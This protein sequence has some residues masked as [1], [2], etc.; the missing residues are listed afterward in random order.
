MKT[1]GVSRGIARGKRFVVSTHVNP[2]ADGVGACVALCWMLR[3]MGKSA[4]LVIIEKLPRNLSFIEKIFPV[5]R[6]FTNAFQ[7][8]D[9]FVVIDSSR[10]ERT[11]VTQAPKGLSIINI[12]HHRDNSR[13][14]DY[15]WV[16]PCAPATAEMVYS[17]ISHYGFKPE[18][19]IAEVLYAGILVDTGGFKFSNTQ[20]RVFSVC[21][22]L[23][24]CGIDCHQLYRTVF[25][26]KSNGRIRLEGLLLSEAVFLRN[27]RICVMT[28]G[29][30]ELQRTGA[31]DSDLEGIS[32]LTMALMSVRIG[33][34]FFRNN[35][36]V[37]ICFRS[38]GSYDIGELAGS[39]GGGGHAAAAG[40][41]LE[42]HWTDVRR[43]VLRGAVTLLTKRGKSS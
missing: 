12:D 33:I 20:T 19:K 29:A 1:A 8:A 6:S 21:A 18:K 7:N 37:K 30:R 14:G 28:I 32:N 24:A 39:F 34:L 41:T 31:R 3:K 22:R 38:D 42:G 13:F 4:Q 16:D 36:S 5:A 40:C 11:G 27:G 26:D 9:T 43:K 17:L 10:I 23:A 15:N 35:D 25:L 2:D